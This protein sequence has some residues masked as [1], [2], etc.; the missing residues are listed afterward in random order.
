VEPLGQEV[1]ALDQPLVAIAPYPP[2]Q[3]RRHRQ[4][5]LVHELITD[6]LAHDRAAGLA[7]ERGVALGPK[8]L[9]GGRHGHLPPARQD[10]DLDS[11]GQ[12]AARA[13]G[14][15][16]SGQHQR[17]SLQG[18]VR[19]GEIAAC[20]QHHQ[21]RVGG[22]MHCAAQ[23]FEVGGQRREHVRRRPVVSGGGPQ[24][25]RPHQHG[26]RKGPQQAH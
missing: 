5:E 26:V 10:L 1:N 21:A 8:Q 18:R 2:G 11:A 24:R 14:A 16:G 15:V 25:P 9:D 3:H 17:P 4:V 20:A 13:T 6:K 22:T 19:R 7:Q 23:D 12:L